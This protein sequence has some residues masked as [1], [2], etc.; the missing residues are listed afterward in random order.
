MSMSVGVF[1]SEQQGGLHHDD[2]AVFSVKEKTG[3]VKEIEEK[4]TEGLYRLMFA[5]RR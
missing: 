3:R 4:K 1:G 5:L 2:H